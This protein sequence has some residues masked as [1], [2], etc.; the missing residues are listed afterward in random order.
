MPT[1]PHV[2]G[3]AVSGK[4]RAGKS[5]LA[6]GLSLALREM[7][8]PVHRLSWADPLKVEVA[9]ELGITVPRLLALKDGAEGPVKASEIRARLQDR[10]IQ[11]RH[12]HIDYWVER[13]LANVPHG[14]IVVNDDTRFENEARH[15]AAAGMLVVRLKVPRE[16]RARRGILSNEDNESETALD[17]YREWDL[18]LDGTMSADLLVARCLRKGG[19]T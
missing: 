1:R 5:T 6:M 11:R 4:Q 10:G 15:A 16:E 8:Y 2:T 3:F 14:A 7:G 9:E 12:E 13:G 17:N 19:F 18:V